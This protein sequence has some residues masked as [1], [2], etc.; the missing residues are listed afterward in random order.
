MA[1]VL[2]DIASPTLRTAN[3]E[4]W[5]FLSQRTSGHLLPLPPPPCVFFFSVPVVKFGM[6]GMLKPRDP[7]CAPPKKVRAGSSGR[8]M[9]EIA[10]G[11]SRSSFVYLALFSVKKK[12]KEAIAPPLP[13]PCLSSDCPGSLFLL[14]NETFSFCCPNAGWGRTV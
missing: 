3:P 7:T 4:T 14:V 5:W 9:Y 8:Y 11:S 6:V 13:C 12:F 2:W 10:L 1:K